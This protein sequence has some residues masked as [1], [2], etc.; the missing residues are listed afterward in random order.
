LERLRAEWLETGTQGDFDIWKHFLPGASETFSYET[1]A[2]KLAIS[3]AALKSEI[4]RLRRRL[5]AL[6]RGEVARTVSAPH[7]IESE[8]THLQHVLMDRGI[9][10]GIKKSE[11]F[12]K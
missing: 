12:G 9:E 2:E 7:E 5:R 3:V 11:T 8:M 6:V 10:I 1:A 4:H